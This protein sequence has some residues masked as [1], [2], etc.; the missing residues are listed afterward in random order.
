MYY[1]NKECNEKQAEE[2]RIF[3]GLLFASEKP[4][5]NEKKPSNIFLRELRKYLSPVFPFF[6]PAYGEIHPKIRT[7]TTGVFHIR[8]Y[9]FFARVQPEIR[10]WKI[11]SVFKVSRPFVR[12]QTGSRTISLLTPCRQ[13]E[14]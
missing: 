8:T 14:R 11:N 9:S 13:A 4:E 12:L 2:E 7:A 3:K 1:T 10:S 6:K 5:L